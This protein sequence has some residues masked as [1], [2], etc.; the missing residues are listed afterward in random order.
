MTQTPSL[1]A[2]VIGDTVRYT[3]SITNSGVDL[4]TYR[5]NRYYSAVTSFV[6]GSVLIDGV[7]ISKPL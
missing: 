4:A 3:L 2:A 5:C 1:G 7:A 6:P